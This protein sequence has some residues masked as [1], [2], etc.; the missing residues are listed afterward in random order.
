MD[1][2]IRELADNAEAF[3]L[4]RSDAARVIAEVELGTR[5]WATVAVGFGIHPEQIPVWSRALDANRERARA[6][7]AHAEAPKRP[8]PP[9][10][11][12]GTGTGGRFTSRDA[13]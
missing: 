4:T 2:D 5:D 3:L 7:E 13:I 6:I 10:A 11:P 1:R 8:M 12:K 9:R